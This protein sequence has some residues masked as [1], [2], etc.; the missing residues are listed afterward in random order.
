MARLLINYGADVNVG[1]HGGLLPTAVWYENESMVKLLLTSGA[2][3]ESKNPIAEYSEVCNYVIRLKCKG[4]TKIIGF[5]NR[6]NDIVYINSVA[7]KTSGKL[8]SFIK[9]NC[10]CKWK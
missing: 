6:G 2:A 1:G 3:I 7:Y 5:D 10:I 4:S 9:R 8:F